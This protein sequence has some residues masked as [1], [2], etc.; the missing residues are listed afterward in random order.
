[1]RRDGISDT[2]DTH[3][4]YDIS[5]LTQADEEYFKNSDNYPPD[6]VSEILSADYCLIARDGQIPVHHTCIA[7]ESFTHPRSKMRLK[8]QSGDAYVYNVKTREK[9]RGEGI[10]P[11]IFNHIGSVVSEDISRLYAEIDSSNMA[12]YNAFSKVDFKQVG[13]LRTYSIRGRDIYF[14]SGDSI[15]ADAFSLPFFP[16]HLSI[17]NF[18]EFERIKKEIR[19]FIESWEQNNNDVVLYG[20]ANHAEELLSGTEIGSVV[21]YTIDDAES[22]ITGEIRSYNIYSSEYILEIEPDVIVLCSRAFRGEMTATL[23]ELDADCKIL[24][25]YPDVHYIE[26]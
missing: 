7:V 15:Y 11:T 21:A 8:L 19:P 25:L 12:I 22:K 13:T 20:A 6:V 4:P 17:T 3:I 26:N 18:S 2:P 16:A 5:L 1:M 9:H 24:S 14:I 23:R 10:S